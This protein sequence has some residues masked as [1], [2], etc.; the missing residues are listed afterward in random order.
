M[1]DIPDDATT[2]ANV[3]LGGT[4][5]GEL[6]TIGDRDWIRIQMTRG[7]RAQINLSGFGSFFE[8]LSDPYIR[9][10]DRNGNLVIDN[11]D[12]NGLDSQVTFN[13]TYTGAYYIEAAG[14]ADQRAGTYQIQTAQITPVTPVGSLTWGTQLDAS[15]PINVFFVGRGGTRFI[16]TGVSYTSEGFNA[17]ER[18]QIMAAL[19]SIANV[20]DLE[21]NIVS[22][23]ADADLQLVLDTNELGPDGDLG[24]FNPPGQTYQGNGV[25]NGVGAGW[26]RTAGGGLEAGGYGYTTIVH[27]LLHG[28]GLAHPHDTGGTSSIMEG[29]TE[30]YNSYGEG[31]LNQGIFTTMSYNSGYPNGPSGSQ[32]ASNLQ[33]G[34]EAGPMALDIA[35]LQSLYGAGNYRGSNTVYNL[36]NSNGNGTSWQSIWD[37]GG[38]DEIRYNGTRDTTI[39]LREATLQ[40]DVGGGG[41]VS[42]ANNISGGFTIANGVMIENATGGGGDDR[43]VGNRGSNELRGNGGN[44]TA[45]G[46]DG[47]DLLWGGDGR[48]YLSGGRDADIL[49]GENGNDRIAGG[50]GRD[51]LRGG[52]GNDVIIGGTDVDALYGGANNDSLYGGSYTDRMKGGAG[53]D[54]LFGGVGHDTLRGEDGEDRL[55]GGRDNDALF[56]GNGND[57]IEGGGGRD[58]AQGNGGQDIFV[59]RGLDDVDRGSS[60]RDIIGDF[61]NDVDTLDLSYIDAD[62]TTGGNQAFDLI[63][64]AGFT[65]AGQLRVQWSDSRIVLQAD[66]DG[67]GI[68]DFEIELRN[69]ASIQS[70]DILL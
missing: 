60:R 65:A 24:V 49:W 68:T 59:F 6:E 39:D 33:Y 21:F 48:D 51:V 2:T 56:G 54:R 53:D 16:D 23:A 55:F 62:A 12:Y 66:I 3:T 17:Y 50:G 26:D 41:F 40:Q 37:T 31:T 34:Y 7:D 63:G 47:D 10:Y 46:R 19:G 57:L 5:Y 28:L 18:A 4:F 13:A 45:Y 22:N 61:T 27:E 43:L 25:F 52:N 36:P 38:T 69:L 1:P 14:Y 70:N 42:M 44:D 30:P 29:V 8:E 67:D 32:G 35:V 20:T 15:A 64:R 11:D 58:R 9:I